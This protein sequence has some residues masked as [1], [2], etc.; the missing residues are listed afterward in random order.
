MSEPFAAAD[1][2]VLRDVPEVSILTSAHEGAVVH[3]TI[4]WVVVDSNDRVLIRS[5]LGPSA[6]W[7]REALARPACR[8]RV[9]DRVLDVHAEA[10]ADP[11]RVASCS[12]ALREKYAA[13]GS[14]PIMLRRYLDTT[15]ELRPRS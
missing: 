7:Y 11:E 9:G 4:I 6:R 10:A 1:L 15:L 5:Y 12:D 8:L 14:M 3:S 13:H 2:A